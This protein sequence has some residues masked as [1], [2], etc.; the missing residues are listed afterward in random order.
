MVWHT[1][2]NVGNHNGRFLATISPAGLEEFFRQVGR[3]AEDPLNPPPVTPP[4]EE[5][6]KQLLAVA[7][8]YM[9]IMPPPAAS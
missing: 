9:G 2:Q 4:T 8:K 6:V 1:Y 5:Q 3:P 7:S